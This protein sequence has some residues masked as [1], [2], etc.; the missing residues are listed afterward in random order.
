[1]FPDFWVLADEISRAPILDAD[2]AAPK[3]PITAL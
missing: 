3:S 1:M 2:G